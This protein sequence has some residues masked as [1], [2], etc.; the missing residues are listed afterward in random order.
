MPFLLFLPQPIAGVAATAMIVTQGWLMLSGNFAWLN[1]LTIVLATAALPGD[2]L[3][4]LPT[5]GTA[6]A[7]PWP[8]V[9]AVVGISVLVALLSIRPARN[10]L[11]PGSG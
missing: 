5:D 11:S 10:L 7:T 8:F 6:T 3:G 9:V 4:W 2:W 1:L